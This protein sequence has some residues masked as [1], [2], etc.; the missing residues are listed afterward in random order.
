MTYA[1]HKSVT[2]ETKLSVGLS[3]LHY[4]DNTDQSIWSNGATQ[5]T[6][7]LYY[8][9]KQST[10]LGRVAL[11]NGGD[12]TVEDLPASLV[13][14]KDGLDILPLQQGLKEVDVLIEIGLKLS[15]PEIARVR[16][17]GGKAVAYKVGNDYVMDVES[18]VFQNR[19]GPI[20]NGS[21]FDQVWSIPQHMRTCSSYWEVGSRCPVVEVPHI[22]SPLFFDSAAAGMA[23][24]AGYQIGRNKKRVAIFEPNLNVVKSCHYPMLVCEQLFRTVPELLESVYVLNT[25]HL[26]EHETFK[27][28]AL[29]LDIVQKKVASFESRHVAP[30]FMAQYADIA[31]AHQWE[32]ELNY[33]YYDML[34]GGWPLVHNSE[35]L[36]KYGYYYESFNAHSGAEALR[37]AAAEHDRNLSKY[38][39]NSLEL[40]RKVDISNADNIRSH[41][42]LLYA[43]FNAT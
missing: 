18:I 28:F 25:E 34:Y 42:R 8:L 35:A 37:R 26:K 27:A 41:E 4:K 32:N 11:L 33:F 21:Q 16:D 12:S 9:L 14:S 22:W 19:K 15:A 40:L 7:F 24:K 29:N 6:F 20:F 36:K 23:G 3:F 39:R 17:R 2:S 38:N 10:R 43:L 1:H 5:N 30:L 13:P 31:V